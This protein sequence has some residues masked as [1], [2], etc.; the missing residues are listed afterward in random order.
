SSTSGSSPSASPTPTGG[1]QPPDGAL[2]VS[3]LPTGAPPRLT[4]V[5][6]DTVHFAGGETTEVRT[7]FA[8]RE[9]V[10]LADG[11]RVW[12]TI[13]DRSRSWVEIQD[14]DGGFHDPVRSR[15]GLS[16][17]RPHSIVA[18][19]TPTGQVMIWEGWASEP[20]PLGDP[21]PGNDLRLGPVTG[22]DGAAP[23]QA[24]PDCEASTC[25]VVVTVADRAWQPWEARETGS[26]PLRD[27]GYL[28]IKDVSSTSLAIG[29][30]EI[31]D[32]GT[33]STL[34]GGGEFQGFTTCR[35]TLRS[36]SPDGRLILGTPA[37]P[38]GAGANQV[39]MYD[40]G[41]EQLFSRGATKRA[42]PTFHATTWE[43]DTHL[44]VPIH[45][46][47]EWSL[48]RIASDGTM[49]YAVAPRREAD[50]LTNPY[51]LPTGGGL[52]RG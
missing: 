4:Y 5:H 50:V 31:R 47:G 1:Q 13:D 46:D 52:P 28:D 24:G 35:H 34:M 7:R 39:A 14:A 51:V 41:S 10:E 2:D 17:N 15:L 44:L 30:T 25:T 42:H 26:Q 16:V 37:Y 8:P 38:D 21:I 43:D 22:A 32:F 20:R 9:L 33:C 3:D 29:W 6:E 11:A 27:G 19:L 23:G 49:E 12:L 48:V 36:F 45:Q 18:W 40:L